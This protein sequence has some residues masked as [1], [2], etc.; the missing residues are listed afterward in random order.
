MFSV[1]SVLGEDLNRTIFGR[2]HIDNESDK[3]WLIKTLGLWLS[4]YLFALAGMIMVLRVTT[5]KSTPASNNDPVYIKT[6]NQILTNTIEQAIIFGGLY[7]ALLFNDSTS[8]KKIGGV[9]VLA[10]ASMFVVG[11]VAFAIGYILAG[12]TKISTLRVFGFA[13][14]FTINALM[15]SYHLG[16]NV[17]N[18]I[19]QNI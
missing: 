15:V 14:G 6:L 18:H 5:G 12:I 10:L 17:F 16:Y 1:L 13:T 2:K 19:S 3:L 8:L 11:R 4:L 9:K 7:A